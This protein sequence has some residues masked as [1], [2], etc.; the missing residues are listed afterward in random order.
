MKLLEDDVLLNNLN[1]K[2]GDVEDVVLT[3]ATELEFWV[4]TPENNDVKVK[5]LSTSQVMQEQYWKRTKGT[6]RTALERSLI[7]L[8][9]YGLEAEMGHKRSWRC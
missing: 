6:V 2:L 9:L 8:D 1:L 5:D 7:L 4:R 3:S